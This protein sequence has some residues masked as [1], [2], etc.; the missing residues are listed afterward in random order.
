MA[1]DWCI[2]D[3]HYRHVAVHLLSRI[4]ATCK[5]L[6][7]SFQALGVHM[8]ASINTIQSHRLPDQ[9]MMARAQQSHWED[10]S[11]RMQV[12]VD[13][14]IARQQMLQIITYLTI[15]GTCHILAG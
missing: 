13:G 8:Q 10:F 1:D 6:Y 7:G 15:H 11:N 4:E 5:G 2:A 3:L 12:A 9:F 14:D